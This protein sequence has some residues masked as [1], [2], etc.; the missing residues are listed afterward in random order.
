[1]GSSYDGAGP[2]NRENVLRF[3]TRYRS[4]SASHRPGFPARHRM[5]GTA[6][7]NV[8]LSARPLISVDL[9]EGVIGQS[10]LV[11]LDRETNTFGKMSELGPGAF[12]N[13]NS[14]IGTIVHEETH[15][16]FGDRLNLGVDRYR[17]MDAAG[18]EESYVQR[19][20]D[21]FLRMQERAGR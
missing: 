5:H 1:M 18:L 8:R 10:R 7:A 19:V 15:L 13:R 21:R 16:R 6:L 17:R 9:P 2:G 20:E 11:L 3:F 14:L 12:R 4:T